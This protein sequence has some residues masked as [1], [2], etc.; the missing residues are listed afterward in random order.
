M[1]C[2]EFSDVVLDIARNQILE[3]R[4]RAAALE[5]V[6]DCDQC[7]VKL[8]EEQQLS[9]H[10]HTLAEVMQSLSAAAQ[11]NPRVIATLRSHSNVLRLRKMRRRRKAWAAAAAAIVLLVIGLTVQLRNALLTPN[12]SAVDLP[13]T[14]EIQVPGQESIRKVSSGLPLE[15]SQNF[16]KD[17]S[18]LI[19]GHSLSLHSSNPAS[20]RSPLVSTKNTR[21]EIATDFF[22]VGDTS[23]SSLADGGQLIRLELPR[24]ALMR[25][26]LPVNMDRADERVK[27]DVLVGS[28]GIA[29][30]I[31]FVE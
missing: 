10:L 4:V 27:A 5:H 17:K 24:S 22:A 19:R 25:F 29:R 9:M 20:V 14:A 2:V 26:G 11:I 23:A 18:K 28:D 15:S 1:N 7:R 30:A 8:E 6:A 21:N 16:V 13:H 12:I 3:A 31:R